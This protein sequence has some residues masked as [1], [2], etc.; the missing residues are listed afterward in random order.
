MEHRLVFL[1]DE[2]ERHRS[3]FQVGA[4]CHRDREEVR[5]SRATRGREDVQ[6]T[7]YRVPLI[8]DVKQPLSGGRGFIFH[9]A[10]DGGVLAGFD[11]W[12]RDGEVCTIKSETA[13]RC[14]ANRARRLSAG[15]MRKRDGDR[16]NDH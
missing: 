16:Q 9:E 10:K 15:P 7:G 6:I 14:L 11:V 3:A 4:M 5:F 2:R 8:I 1:G 13:G 12:N